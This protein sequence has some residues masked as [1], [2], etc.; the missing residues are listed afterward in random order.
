MSRHDNIDG[1]NLIFLVGCPRSGTT[2][3]QRLLACH[4]L[5][6][7]GQ[8]SKIFYGHIGP[9]VMYWRDCLDREKHRGG[10]GLPAYITEEEFFTILKSFLDDLLQPLIGPL[11]NGELF[12]EKT[13]DHALSIR[14][15]VRLLPKS[16]IIHLLRDPRDVVA[17]LLAASRTWATTWAPGKAKEA[18]WLWAH[19]VK[20]V[21]EA[22]KELPTWQ[23]FELT[24]EELFHEP[25]KSLQSCVTFL[26]LSWNE[27][28]I[29]TAINMNTRQMALQTGGGTP[30]PLGGEIAKMPGDRVIEPEGF[31]RRACPGCWRKDLNIV[32]KF[33]T[34]K[35]ARRVMNEVGYQWRFPL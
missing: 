1:H 28:D 34:W 7:T 25:L 24:Y 35:F 20:Y 33:W 12:L 22:K 13:P 27:D 3:L 10:A 11:Q 18:A 8:E 4:P 9:Q 14:E 32:E 30:I 17:S 26:N 6:R 2:W 21:C 15:I 5:I 16:R 29:Q 19:V 23:F 31:I